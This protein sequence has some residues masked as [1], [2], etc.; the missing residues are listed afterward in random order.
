MF[1]IHAKYIK[2]WL[3]SV[4]INVR[5]YV[6]EVMRTNFVTMIR[7]EPL[8]GLRCQSWM[9]SVDVEEFSLPKIARNEATETVNGQ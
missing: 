9:I 3:S 7:H 4:I 5:R 6:I 8:W 2:S 1:T